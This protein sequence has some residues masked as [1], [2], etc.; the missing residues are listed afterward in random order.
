MPGPIS[1]RTGTGLLLVRSFGIKLFATIFAF[2]LLWAILG[3]VLKLRFVPIPRY[4]KQ[5]SIAI[6]TGKGPFELSTPAGI[7]NPVI[8]TSDVIEIESKVV[9]DPFMIR[10]GSEWYLFFEVLNRNTEVGNIAYAVSQDGLS[11]KYGKIIIKE[12]FHMS[13]PYVFEWQNDYYMIPET[14]EAQSIRLYKAVDF[15]QKWVHVCDLARGGKFVD[16]SVV[17]HDG[18]WWLFTQ[19]GDFRDGILRLF[20]SENLEGPWKEHPKSPV[21]K[22][23]P[24]YARGGGRIISHEGKLFRLAQDDYPDYGS[25]VWPIEIEE[26]TTDSYSERKFGDKPVVEAGSLWWNSEGMHTVDPHQVGENRWIAC[27]DGYR[28]RW[29]LDYNR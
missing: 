12:P 10:K 8:I 26:L 4:E 15:P 28:W 2:L 6:L 9:A 11:W 27:V 14:G 21:V 18:K 19:T 17:R 3:L 13:Y 1:T 7:K 20:Y 16:T 24:H 29:L 23:E 25:K 22:N 5:W